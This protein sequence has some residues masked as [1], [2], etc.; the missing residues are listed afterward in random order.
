[1]KSSFSEFPKISGDG[2]GCC[3]KLTDLH[4]SITTVK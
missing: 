4:I 2:T 3:K 1:M